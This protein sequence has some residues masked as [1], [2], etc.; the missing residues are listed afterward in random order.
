MSW[1]GNIFPCWGARKQGVHDLSAVPREMKPSRGSERNVKRS[2]WKDRSSCY[3]NTVE[4]EAAENQHI[5]VEPDSMNFKADAL[6]HTE[7][8]QGQ[9]PSLSEIGRPF[10][11][12]PKNPALPPS[13]DPQAKLLYA[14]KI[15]PECLSEAS[16]ALIYKGA[17]ASYRWKGL[18]PISRSFFMFTLLVA[19]DTGVD[20]WSASSEAQQRRNRS[21]EQRRRYR[22]LEKQGGLG[23]G[24]TTMKCFPV[25]LEMPEEEMKRDARTALYSIWTSSGPTVYS[26]LK[27]MPMLEDMFLGLETEEKLILAFCDRAFRR[28]D[29]LDIENSGFVRVSSVLA[30]EFSSYATKRKTISSKL[31]SYYH[32][33]LETVR[34]AADSLLSNQSGGEL[35]LTSASLSHMVDEI[36]TIAND[37][38]ETG[39]VRDYYAPTDDIVDNRLKEIAREFI[40]QHKPRV[41]SIDRDR[42]EQ[43]TL[44]GVWK[45]EFLETAHAFVLRDWGLIFLFYTPLIRQPDTLRIT[46]EQH[47]LG[48][49][50]QNYASAIFQAPYP[51]SYFDIKGHL[52]GYPANPAGAVASMLQSIPP[53]EVFINNVPAPRISQS[54]DIVAI[55]REPSSIRASLLVVSCFGLLLVRRSWGENQDELVIPSGEVFAGEKPSDGG[56]RVLEEKTGLKGELSLID[57]DKHTGT[58]DDRSWYQP[59]YRVKLNHEWSEIPLSDKDQNFEWVQDEKDL[60]SFPGQGKLKLAPEWREIAQKGLQLWKETYDPGIKRK[61]Q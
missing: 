3:V 2:P 41:E 33:F 46:W 50:G 14:V 34:K 30:S 26:A 49:L 7:L 37:M 44:R 17:T 19:W 24:Q 56:K 6:S 48:E 27:Q 1:F 60:E 42:I 57:F 31:V 9:V 55:N 5:G 43:Y 20:I 29:N 35:Q 54:K 52:S 47:E 61:S 59:N 12:I 15:G 25:M 21:A 36:I 45:G 39:H 16:R 38:N 28:A 53:D 32:P 23:R 4:G 13:Q 18:N 51:A 22:E 11:S 10:A 8:D 58:M 40:R